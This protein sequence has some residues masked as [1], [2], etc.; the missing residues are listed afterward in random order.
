MLYVCRL[1][2]WE[3][4]LLATHHQHHNLNWSFS[5]IDCMD[6]DADDYHSPITIYKIDSALLSPSPSPA[7]NKI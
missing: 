3:Q 5:V 4:A 2:E 6:E 7:N 1:R